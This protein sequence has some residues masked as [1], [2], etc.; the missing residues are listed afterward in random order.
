MQDLRTA[1]RAV[2]AGL[3]IPVD[4]YARLEGAGVIVPEL[5]ER[6]RAAL[7]EQNTEQHQETVH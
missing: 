1:R 6:L 4:V 2:A 3:P 5:E 7:R